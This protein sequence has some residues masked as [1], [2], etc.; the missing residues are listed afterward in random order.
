MYKIAK[1]VFK[2]LIEYTGYNLFLSTLM[3]S[4]LITVSQVVV[5]A[6]LF[7]L[8]EVVLSEKKELEILSYTLSQDVIVYIYIMIILLSLMTRTIG[9][10][11]YLKIAHSTGNRLLVNILKNIP[12][13]SVDLFSQQSTA[14]FTN[15]LTNL[16][17]Q[18]VSNVFN[19]FFELI[20][21]FLQTFL[22][23]VILLTFLDASILIALILVTVL[24]LISM[25]LVR[26]RLVKLGNEYVANSQ[27]LYNSVM[28]MHRASEELRQGIPFDYFINKYSNADILMRSTIRRTVVASSVPKVIL[29]TLISLLVIIFLLTVSS[30]EALVYMLEPDKLIPTGVA[31]L[32][33]IPSVQGILTS[34]GALLSSDA[35]LKAIV[36]YEKQLRVFNST[37][38]VSLSIAVDKISEFIRTNDLIVVS[39]E[40]GV[41]KSRFLK[42]LVGLEPVF[43]EDNGG[44]FFPVEDILTKKSDWIYLSATPWTIR[45]SL[46]VNISFDKDRNIAHEIEQMRLSELA[47]VNEIGDK[48]SHGQGQ[49]ISVLRAKVLG[50][51]NIILDET[52]SGLDPDLFNTTLRYVS[53][54]F[55]K[56]IIVSHGHDSRLEGVPTLKLLPA[57]RPKN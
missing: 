28:E 48:V 52:L 15:L 40:S 42:G 25:S 20:T 29:E 38:T 2:F 43:V 10:N 34:Y 8:I 13:R 33:L 32:R 31:A 35:V 55:E 1:N 41:G 46:N 37:F 45:D 47:D 30:N 17:R 22:I 51:R 57:N 19:P 49:R 27:T 54:N 24:Y 14:G 6:L 39:G 56:V 12:Q 3:L 5:I 21:S 36:N 4:I 44:K 23:V 53:N 11:Y 16:N 18:I 50:Y 7:P 9:V 26:N